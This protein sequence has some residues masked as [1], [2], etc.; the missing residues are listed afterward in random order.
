MTSRLSLI[1]ICGGQGADHGAESAAVDESDLAKVQDD[2]AA[3][4][5]EPDHMLSERITLPS[6]DDASVA[7]DDGDASHL[8]GIKR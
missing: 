1:H 7:M 6:G 8:T 2:G 3:V 5:Q 4:A